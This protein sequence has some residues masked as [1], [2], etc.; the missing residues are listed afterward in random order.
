MGKNEEEEISNPRVGGWTISFNSKNIE[1]DIS[2]IHNL[3]PPHLSRPPPTKQPLT[4]IG[5]AEVSSKIFLTYVI[6]FCKRMHRLVPNA[7]FCKI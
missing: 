4:K 6:Y 2:K 5:N 3:D 1:L 7:P